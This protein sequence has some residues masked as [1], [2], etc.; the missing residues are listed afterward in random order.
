MPTMPAISAQRTGPW[1]SGISRHSAMPARKNVTAHSEF[2]IALKR[3]FVV[4]TAYQEKHSA[5]MMM[6]TITHAMF[7][8]VSAPVMVPS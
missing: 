8:T 3:K 4:T 1:N 5:M 2:S 7:T 6:G